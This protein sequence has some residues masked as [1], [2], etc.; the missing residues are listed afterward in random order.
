MRK[1]NY[2]FM[3]KYFIHGLEWDFLEDPTIQQI[4]NN[5]DQIHEDGRVYVFE[6]NDNKIKIG[7]DIYDNILTYDS[8]K[9]N[10]I[11]A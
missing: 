11:I 5:F 2:S 4:K 6:L 10:Y 7:N 9:K 1:V 8:L 3:Q